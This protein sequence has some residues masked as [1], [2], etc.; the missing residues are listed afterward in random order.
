MENILQ[1]HFLDIFFIIIIDSTNLI[2][3]VMYNSVQIYFLFGGYYEDENV[4]ETLLSLNDLVFL[5][6]F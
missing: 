4:S 2:I 3:L 1:K 5:C 6:V